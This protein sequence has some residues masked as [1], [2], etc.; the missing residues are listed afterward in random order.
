ME[1]VLTID[2][3]YDDLNRL[4]DIL[5]QSQSFVALPRDDIYNFHSYLVPTSPLHNTCAILDRNC[6]TRITNLIKGNE[7]PQNEIDDYRWAAAVM[8]FC[9][10][11]EITFDYYSSLQELASTHGGNDAA[12]EFEAFY[13][14]DNSDPQQFL[15]FALGRTNQLTKPS[16]DIIAPPK[17]VPHSS[18]FENRI[19]EFRINYIMSLK[20]ALI[21]EEQGVGVTSMISFIDW[22]DDEF[23]LGGSALHFANLLFSPS[24]MKKMLKQKRIDDIKNTAWDFALIQ[25]WCTNALT[26]EHTKEH[27]FLITRDKVVRYIANRLVAADEQEFRSF[28][29]DAWKNNTKG[30]QQVYERY[31]ALHTKLAKT[32]QNRFK[33]YSD[34]ERAQFKKRRPF[35]DEQ[36]DTITQELEHKYLS[37]RLDKGEYL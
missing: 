26:F 27:I 21:E 31:M 9:Q 36:L 24:R 35:S 17:K 8:A 37:L 32:M 34:E 30:G 14:A 20:I 6:Y 1:W 23:M 4:S 13:Y 12:E 15:D 10:I 19:Y 5:R 28:I 11:A 22:M 16:T 3:H 7:V 29:V 33:K 2:Y 25:N 18:L